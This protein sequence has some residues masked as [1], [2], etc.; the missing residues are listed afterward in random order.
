MKNTA[1]TQCLDVIFTLLTAIFQKAAHKVQDAKEFGGV[2]LGSAQQFL[3]LRRAMPVRSMRRGLAANF[4]FSHQELVVQIQRLGG[5]PQRAQEVS[6]NTYDDLQGRGAKLPKYWE[7]YAL[8]EFNP[9]NASTSAALGRALKWARLGGLDDAT[10]MDI[11]N[12]LPV[13]LRYD[14]ADALELESGLRIISEDE[15]A[16]ERWDRD[17]IG[18]S[19]MSEVDGGQ[20]GYDIIASRPPKPKPGEDKP[21]GQD[22][23]DDQEPPRD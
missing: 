20:D 16:V 23:D 19:S 8:L 21:P 5:D 18:A 17:N 13:S 9:G 6:Q 4:H 14:L 7:L 15:E 1:V 11:V 3:T 12:Q 22:D 2:F 10:I